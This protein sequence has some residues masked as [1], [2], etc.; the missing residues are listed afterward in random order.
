MLDLSSTVSCKHHIKTAITAAI[1]LFLTRS[2]RF[3][4]DAQGNIEVDLCI[5]H[6]TSHIQMEIS[7]TIAQPQPASSHV[8]L[9]LRLPLRPR[10]IATSRPRTADQVHMAL[11]RSKGPSLLPRPLLNSSPRLTINHQPNRGECLPRLIDDYCLVCTLPD[12]QRRRTIE[13]AEECRS[14]EVE[15]GDQTL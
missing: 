15:L 7:S 4:T 11:S 12:Q 10:F 2:P 9:R 3:R 1:V 8:R 13:A 5:G 6:N 14:Q